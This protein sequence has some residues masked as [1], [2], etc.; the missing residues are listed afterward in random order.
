MATAAGTQPFPG[1]TSGNSGEDEILELPVPPIGPAPP[2]GRKRMPPMM[3]TDP[4]ILNALR[5]IE[6]ERVSALPIIPIEA[7]AAKAG[8]SLH[9]FQRRFSAVMGETVGAYVRRQRLETAAI[10]LQMTPTPILQTAV[11]VGY[12][13][14]EA[15]ARAFQR[16]F[17]RSPSDY[18]AWSAGAALQPGPL[19]RQRAEH[20]VA[21][22]RDAIDL[23][24]VRFFGSHARVGEYWSAFAKLLAEAGIEPRGRRFFGMSLDN[25]EITPRGLIRYDCAI[26]MPAQLPAALDRLPFS[27]LT[28]P[29]T[30]VARFRH[31]GPYLSVFASYRAIIM[32]VTEKRQQFGDAPAVEAY[33]GL[34]WLDGLDEPVSFAIELGIV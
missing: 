25:P 26:E 4:V 15:F 9:H 30:R 14:A 20:V 7:I 1:A 8:L 34:P 23:L 3:P 22:W 29:R 19:E 11:A 2:A 24:A 10:L 27:R 17:G 28:L 16:Q 12:N 13:S 31:E 6:R 5:A 21:D 32:W 33:E 18:R